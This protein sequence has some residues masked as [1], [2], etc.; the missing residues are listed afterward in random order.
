[1]RAARSPQ[2]PSLVPWWVWQAGGRGSPPG[3]PAAKVQAPGSPPPGAAA[4]TV[5]G[6]GRNRPPLPACGWVSGLRVLLLLRRRSLRLNRPLSLNT[7][8]SGPASA[9]TQGSS[10]QLVVSHCKPIRCQTQ[11]S[12]PLHPRTR[13]V[14][15]LHPLHRLALAAVAGRLD[16]AT[17]K[18]AG[19][20]GLVAVVQG[21]GRFTIRGRQLHG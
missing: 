13:M 7:Q 17:L 19:T 20:W 4:P 11:C 15:L 10:P 5:A 9:R 16:D 3:T 8:R 14:A 12:P 21:D 2:T 6:R 1:V 18:C